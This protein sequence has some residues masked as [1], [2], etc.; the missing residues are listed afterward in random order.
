M[1]GLSWILYGKS[2]T[3]KFQFHFTWHTNH[4][5]YKYVYGTDISDDGKSFS[6]E[7]ES[8][9]NSRG[10][11]ILINRRPRAA[12][13]L[14]NSDKLSIGQIYGANWFFRNAAPCFA[15]AGHKSATFY[16]IIV[17]W[18]WGAIH[19]DRTVYTAFLFPACNYRFVIFFLDEAIKKCSFKGVSWFSLNISF[20]K[21]IS[22][23]TIRPN[24]I[25]F[26][27]R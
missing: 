7:M 10:F 5:Y 24:S 2:N 14:L 3:H 12:P 25:R 1:L 23:P 26:G 27:R 8:Y 11:V 19:F 17:S 20:C 6:I 15:R 22:K 16:V 9:H 18:K 4:Y 13:S 21:V